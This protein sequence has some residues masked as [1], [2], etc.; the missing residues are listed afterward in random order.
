[1]APGGRA[2]P[3]PGLAVQ[4]AVRVVFARFRELGSAR[5]VL[6]QL[7]AR[8]CISAPSDG[9]E[10][11][12]RLVPHP[13]PQHRR[14]RAQEPILRRGLRLRE[15]REAH[16][17][18]RWPTAP[19]YGHGKPLE[20]WEVLSGI[21]TRVYR[22]GPSSRG[23]KRRWRPTTTASPAMPSPAA[24]GGLC[25]RDHQLWPL[26][27]PSAGILPARYPRPV[28]RCDRPTDAGAATL[29]GF[30]GSR[31]DAAVA[32][33]FCGRWSRWRSRRHARRSG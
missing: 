26:W 3:R 14:R 7:T 21:T 28:Y 32:A 5:Q 13:L 31:V 9:S 19:S 33:E 22:D 15:K 2:W 29:L 11:E 18:R 17:A 6:L 1:M 10:D 27:P 25:G 12:F 24:A 20:Q 16:R 30:G 8:A 23:T 4:K